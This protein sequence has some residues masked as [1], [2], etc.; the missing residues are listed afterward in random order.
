MSDP[1]IVVVGA[2]QAGGWAA[3]TLR[4]EGFE[5]RIAVIG[6]EPYPPYERPPL[7]K[8]VLLGREPAESSYLWPDG[9][10]DGWGVELR[11]GVAATGIDRTAKT[12]SLGDGETLA[13]DKLLIATGGRVRKLPLEGA[14][15]D[16]VHYLR[17]IDDSAAIRA[18]LGAG[19]RIVVIG[20]GWIGLEVAAAARTLG[21]EVAVVEALDMLCARALTPDMA[22]YLLDV[23]RGR[24]VDVR[25][26]AAVEALTGQ[27]RVSGARLAGGETLA[28]T[29]V[30]IGIGIVPNVELA[31]AAGIAVDN[32]IRVDA[33]CRTS[34]PDI[35]AAGDVTNHPNRLLGRNIRLESWENAQNQGIAAARAMLGGETPYCEI[36]WFWSDQYDVNIQLVGLPSAFDD[37]VTRGE[38]AQ[39]SFVEFYMK[40]GRIDGAA[41]INSPRDIRFAR[42]LMQAEKIVD[43][44]ALADPA[45]KLQALLRG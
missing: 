29:A 25:L 41:A 10:F 39:G 18:D 33:L 24:G 37:T 15:L 22:A 14:A 12:V 11:T 16:G 7:S 1:G 45:V 35:F 28:A 31:R 13:Y 32:G 38:R 36:P 3:K 20:G 30:V 42:R 43:P 9:S 4:D 40:D 26:G 21:A 44:A 8:E 5:G 17:G 27:G 34:D 23:H 19:A 2:G 6:E